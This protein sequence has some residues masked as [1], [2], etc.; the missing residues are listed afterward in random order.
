ML[1]CGPASRPSS[2]PRKRLGKSARRWERLVVQ[3]TKQQYPAAGFYLFRPM[4][5]REITTADILNEFTT[6]EKTAL[7]NIQGAT[8]QLQSVLSNVVAALRGCI[9]AGQYQ[10]GL[11]NTIPDQ[12]RT[13]VIDVV[14]WRWLVS[15]PKL[16]TLQTDGRKAAYDT[17]VEQFNS[18]ATRQLSVESPMQSSTVL[19]NSE[20]KLVMRTHGSPQPAAQWPQTY[21]G[22]ANPDGPKD[23]AAT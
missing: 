13:C 3:A 19:W 11:P 6:D 16:E 5:W 18:I 7:N 23:N 17:A 10:L 8:T 22:Y 4:A 14:R 1:S 21:N 15:F 12:F 2:P 9:S 20:P